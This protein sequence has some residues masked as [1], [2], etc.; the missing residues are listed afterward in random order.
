MV[1]AEEISQIERKEVNC[2]LLHLH[3]IAKNYVFSLLELTH[4]YF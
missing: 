2:L 4:V 3:R 1:A